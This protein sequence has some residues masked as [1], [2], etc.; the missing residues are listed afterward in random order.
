MMSYLTRFQVSSVL[1]AAFGRAKFSAP[2]REVLFVPT[3][4][5]LPK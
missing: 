3:R 4:K 5:R 1:V 2:L